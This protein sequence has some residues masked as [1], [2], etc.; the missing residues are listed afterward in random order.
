MVKPIPYK[1][2]QAAYERSRRAWRKASDKP[3]AFPRMN[4]T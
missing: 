4:T 3:L 1:R 2:K